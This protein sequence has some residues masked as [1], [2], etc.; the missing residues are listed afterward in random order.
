ELR[1]TFRQAL[2]YP[3]LMGIVA[4]VGVTVLL[5]FVVPRFVQMLGETGGSFPVSTRLLIAMSGFVRHWWWVIA[6][7]VVGSWLGGQSW[8]RDPANRRRLD[9]QRLS[10]PLVGSLEREICTARFARAFG[11]LLRGGV[12][13][14]SALR[15]ALDAVPNAAIKQQLEESAAKV[16]RGESLALSL[17][18]TF[19]PL[20]TQLF[21]VGEESGGGALGTMALRVAD[22]YD[23]ET[24][25]SLRGMVALVE[26]VLIVV[27]GGVVGF[28][29]LAMLQAVYAINGGLT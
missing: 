10:W 14:L 1:A 12:G 11:T 20:A 17:D 3:A 29:A 15:I 25:R 24:Q 7:A 21:A 16:A 26:P 6:G 5:M 13:V 27:F 22:S 4:G 9:A 23:V 2:W 19:P 28:V 8:L 18:G